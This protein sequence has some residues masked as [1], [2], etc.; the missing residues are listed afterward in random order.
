MAIK[1]LRK[2]KKPPNLE[3]VIVPSP[4]VFVK[5]FTD[6]IQV[7]VVADR[8]IFSKQFRNG[9]T[10]KRT[11]KPKGDWGMKSGFTAIQN[12]FG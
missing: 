11:P 8:R 5:Q 9:K 1:P 10:Q 3:R 4:H 7:N 6:K 12:K 2:N